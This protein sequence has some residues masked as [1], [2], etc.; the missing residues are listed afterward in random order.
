MSMILFSW[1]GGTSVAVPFK[2]QENI[3]P[4]TSVE[5]GNESGSIELHPLSITGTYYWNK[6]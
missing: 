1:T 6:T 5:L 2:L 4:L 3:V